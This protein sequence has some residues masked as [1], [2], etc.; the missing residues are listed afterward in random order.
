MTDSNEPTREQIIRTQLTREQVIDQIEGVHHARFDPSSDLD[1]WDQLLACEAVAES[2]PVQDE[3]PHTEKE[4][5]NE[6]AVVNGN[7]NG[8]RKLSANFELTQDKLKVINELKRCNYRTSPVQIA[9]LLEQLFED[10]TTY[11]GHWLYTAQDRTPKAINSV[12]AEMV[13]LSKTGFK[14][15]DKPAAYFTKLLKYH[16]IR[17]EPKRKEFERT[18]G[19]RK[20]QGGTT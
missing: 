20:Q 2:T 15:I 17:K 3:L 11:P 16:P 14:T 5:T 12:L 19:T 6:T 13:K 10:P 18:N 7:V 9:Q 8:A 4:G 1:A